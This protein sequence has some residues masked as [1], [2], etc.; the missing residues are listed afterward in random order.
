ML[1]ANYSNNKKPLS[2]G[3]LAKSVSVFKKQQRRSI[4]LANR[5]SIR[6]VFG[7]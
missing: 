3:I 7:R 6:R 5:A 1:Q 2:M 4:R